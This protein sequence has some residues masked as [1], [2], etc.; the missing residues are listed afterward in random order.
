MLTPAENERCSQVGPGTPMGNVMRRYWQAALLSEE[1]PE[2][3]GAPVRVRLLGEDLIAFR[4][5]EGHVGLVD[6][7]CPHR[8][9]P[10]FFGRNEECGLRCVYHGWKF[11]RNGTCVDMP[12]EP[13]DSLFKTKV[14]IAAYPVWEG[15]GILWAYLGP[16]AT[17]PPPPNYELVRTPPA[18]RYVTKNLQECN[19]LQA[20]EG[21]IDSVHSGFL[22]NN[23][24]SETGFM[25]RNL[26]TVEFD[27]TPY[28]LAG[29][30]V[31]PLDDGEQYART[32]HYVM[33]AQQI[34]ARYL[35]RTGTPQKIPSV[36]AQMWVPIDDATCW[37]YSYSYSADPAIPLTREFIA[38]N[39]STF[40]RGPGDVLP[41]FR[42]RRN[43][44]NDYLIDR[45]RQKTT[46]YTGIEGMGT[47]DIALQE[48]MGTLADRSKEHLAPSDQVIIATR[49]LLFE[50]LEALERGEPL[51]GTAPAS[52]ERV[53]A[54]DAIMPSGVD[55]REDFDQALLAKY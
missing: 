38:A 50:A 15:G 43:A 53:R 25:R 2:N 31:H 40:G 17:M 36:N 44:S 23:D 19:W 4:D 41:G 32:F 42:L 10:M 39:E 27:R 52:H 20:L 11:D 13:P 28:G 24:L 55:W 46:S 48:Q 35:N 30:A 29:A 26:P 12:S 8:R 6:A 49:R 9:A 47:Q 1:L 7:F 37:L 5:S 18:H 16:P 54:A 21:G 3:D 14:T 45:E 34:R 51:R 22:H 33:P